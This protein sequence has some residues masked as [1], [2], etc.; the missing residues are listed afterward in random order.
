MNP[1]PDAGPSPASLIRVWDAPLRMFHWTLAA[2]VVAALVTGWLG[3]GLMVWHGRLGMLILGLLVFR[4]AWGVL[5]S[6]YARW[7]RICLAPFGVLAYLRGQWREP[8]HSP[9]G[10]LATL[11]LLSVLGLQVASGLFA[12]D[13]IAFRGPLQRLVD[14]GTSDW[15]TGVHRQAKWLVLGMIGLHLAAIAFYQ[16]VQRR[17]LVRA[18]ISGRCPREFASQRDAVGGAWWALLL[19]VGLAVLVVWLVQAAP[20]WLTPPAPPP[21]PAVLDW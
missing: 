7:S 2:S 15:L 20:D 6:T 17:P 8:G 10:S 3:G 1:T 4:L 12:N 13:D 5:G 16:L 9:L 18:M 19:A 21:A 11:G 14:G